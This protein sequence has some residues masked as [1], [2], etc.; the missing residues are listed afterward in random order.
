VTLGIVIGILVG[1][2]LGIGLL[3]AFTHLSG[4]QTALR[5]VPAKTYSNVEEWEIIKDPKTGRTLGIR[6][7]RKAEET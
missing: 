4:Q 1:I 6:V 7:H 5:Y 2:P 3:W